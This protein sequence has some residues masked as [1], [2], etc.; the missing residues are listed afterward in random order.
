MTWFSVTD[1]CR[2]LAI[3]AKTLRRWLAQAQVPLLPHPSDG[4][5]KALTAEQLRRLATLHHRGLP[6]LPAAEVWPLPA[7][8][9]AE[10]PPV[11]PEVLALLQPLQALP[12][13]LAAL[14]QQVADL[15]RRLS[16]PQP[17]APPAS[18]PGTPGARPTAKA[19]PK[20]EHVIARVEY[21]GEGRYVVICPTCGI[22]PVVPDTEAWFAWVTEQ[23]SFRFVGQSGHFT[24][25]HEWRVPNG[26]W[27]AHRH[28]RH[29]NHIVRLAPNH[30]L[31]TAVLEQA[32]ASLQAHLS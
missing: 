11:S 4:R 8:P 27:R 1:C 3:D 26:A 28:I 30:Q 21:A 12:A 32:A 31:T 13:H 14:Q 2:L 25:H 9:P 29:R 22:L 23:T 16:Q 17:A 10:P 15:S 5:I 20:S 7:L 19:P 24:A 18:A 6:A